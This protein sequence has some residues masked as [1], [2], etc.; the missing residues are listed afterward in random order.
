VCA[1]FVA[2]ALSYAMRETFAFRGVR[3]LATAHASEGLARSDR[4]PHAPFLPQPRGAQSPLPL[5]EG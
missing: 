3:W 2:A 1:L 4:P 5:G